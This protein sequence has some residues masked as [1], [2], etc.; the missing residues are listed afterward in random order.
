[1][2]CIHAVAYRV[3][4]ARLPI[5]CV[6]SFVLCALLCAAGKSQDHAGSGE[7]IGTVHDLQGR[8]V[9]SAKVQL[10]IA[11]SQFR[12][13]TQPLTTQTDAQ[14]RYHFAA[15][16]EGSYILHAAMAG[17]VDATLP[18]IFLGPKETKTVDFSMTP[19]KT[20]PSA[21]ATAAKAEFFDP[22]SFTVAGVTDTTSLGGHGSDTVVRTREAVAKEAASLGDGSR[23]AQP[24]PQA[25]TEKLRERVEREPGSFEANSRLGRV[26]LESGHARDAI[27]YLAHAAQL[28][29][30]NFETA[31]ELAMAYADAGD[32]DRARAQALAL[33]AVRETAE[34]HH[35]LGDVQ[36]KMGDSL[37]AVHEYQRAA[38]LA[39][40]EKYLF[41]WG[42]ELLLHH[43]PEPALEVFTKGNHLFPESVRMLVGLGAS[44]FARGSEEEAVRRICQAADLNPNDPVPYLFLGR[45]QEAERLPSGEVADRLRRFVT[46]QPQNAEANYYY[47]VNLWKLRK[48]PQ[49]SS[50]AQVESLLNRA[51]EID[52]EFGAAYLQLGILHS[53]RK[54]FPKAIANY[55]HAIR[56]DPGMVEAHF[57]LAQVYRQTGDEDQAKA[58][59]QLYDQ[60]VRQSAERDQ[61]ERHEIRQFVYTLRDQPAPQKP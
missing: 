44:W 39:P 60:I 43:A 50:G 25:S 10:Q 9:A 28:N 2:G 27:P 16:S 20:P 45:M 55:Q 17:Y 51:V 14:G 49:D 47:A 37:D 18:P 57:R 13:G 29:S 7:L 36:E 40:T 32:L 21:S 11:D 22:P 15:L 59:L 38:E 26:L 58:E 35:L 33:L 31:Y 53:E 5:W 12:N 34:V 42:A 52:P 61:R 46:L 1:M 41:D 54:H 4:S 6:A 8:P 30:S 56:A 48:S 19:V 23:D 24:P 3:R